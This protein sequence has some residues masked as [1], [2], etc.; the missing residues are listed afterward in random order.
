MT[1]LQSDINPYFAN[2][3]FP[4][5]IFIPAQADRSIALPEPTAQIESETYILSEHSDGAGT[6]QLIHNI[7][8]KHVIFVHGSPTYLGDLTALEELQNR[9]H[10]HSPA[11][12]T[13]VALPVSDT[14]IQPAPPADP[15]YEGELTEL[16]R[17]VKISLP[18]AIANDPRWHN[19]GDTGLL[20][21]RW[22]GEEIVLRGISQRELI[23][24]DRASQ[25]S[26]DTHCCGNCLHQRG[27]RCSNP[28]SPLNGFKVTPDGYC[29]AF[30]G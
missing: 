21:A 7:R 25:I 6:T 14:F 1:D 17:E 22:Q 3:P 26:P 20:E 24:R 15:H 8:P 4:W 9:Y 27:D 5:S 16:E 18:E 11:A 28:R 19:F 2:H 12:G 13:V 23:N 29:P 30:E 10:L